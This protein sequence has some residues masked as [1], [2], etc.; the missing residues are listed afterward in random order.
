[1]TRSKWLVWLLGQNMNDFKSEVQKVRSNNYMLEYKSPTDAELKK[2]K[3]LS[4]KEKKIDTTTT[5]IE[6]MLDNLPED[7]I[8][9]LLAKHINKE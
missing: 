9:K 4:A 6:K 3:L 8:K 5:N 1:M 2:I 7:V